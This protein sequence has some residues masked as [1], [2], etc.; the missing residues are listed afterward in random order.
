MQKMIL[1]LLTDNII[2]PIKMQ[3]KEVKMENW[4][5]LKKEEKMVRPMTRI[6]INLITK[7]KFK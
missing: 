5:K 7:T 2:G 3:I 4:N 6:N 1:S